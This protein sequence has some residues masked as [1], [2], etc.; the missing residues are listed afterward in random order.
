MYE[1]KLAIV[2][3]DITDINA[4]NIEKHVKKFSD[5]EGKLN[6]LGIWK[7]TN[8]VAPKDRD[9]PM[10]KMDE[11]GNLITARAPGPIKKH[12]LETYRNRLKNRDIAEGLEDIK[13]LKEQLWS[14]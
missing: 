11:F 6:H 10:A 1:S 13:E 14:R 3:S 4:N 7:V 5:S 9:P 2:E 8:M 12:Y